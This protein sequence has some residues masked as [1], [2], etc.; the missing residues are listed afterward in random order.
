MWTV[1]IQAFWLGI[2]ATII[3]DIYALAMK[4]IFGVSSLNYALVGRWVSHMF[5]GQFFH[6]NI[7][8]SPPA[9]LESLLGWGVHYLVGIL[10]AGTFLYMSGSDWLGEPSLTAALT[11]GFVTVI[12]PFALLQPAMGAGIAAS[13]TPNPN[14]ARMKSVCAHLCF[15]FGLWFTA[16][17]WNAF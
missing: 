5:Q 3:M 4:R 2:G 10:F 9:P 17:I 12:A 1:L 6:Q 13:K 11:F 7:A 16:L 15:G 8:N 14:A